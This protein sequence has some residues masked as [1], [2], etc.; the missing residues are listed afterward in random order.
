[1]DLLVGFDSAWTAGKQG[2]ITAVLRTAHGDCRNALT[3]RPATFPAAT[4][5]IQRL[6]QDLRPS[7]TLILLDQ[8]TIVTNTTGQRPVESIVCSVV[9]LRHG[10]MQPAHRGRAEMFGDDAPVWPF[11]RAFGGPAHALDDLP[12]NDDQTTFVLETY[13][14]LVLIALG[15]LL[16]DARATGRLPKYNPE[17]RRTFELADWAFVCENV[18]AA[19]DAHAASET[20]AHVRAM[21]RGRPRKV[22]QDCL[23][24]CI[25]LLVA[26]H[27]ASNRPHLVVG[28]RDSGHIVVP[29]GDALAAELA[30]RCNITERDPAAWLQ[31]R[32]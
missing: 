23:D 24:A 14:V 5:T 19:L 25:C 30:A 12:E 22:D 7:R 18:G 28:Q 15:W 32:R 4:E 1:M 16:P 8:P 9:S 6:Q 26:L 21:M 29:H 17:R 27:I 31:T 2:A 11:L 20:A 3:P 13:P 10:G